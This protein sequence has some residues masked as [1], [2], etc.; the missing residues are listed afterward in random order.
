MRI[1]HPENIRFTSIKANGR[2]IHFYYEGDYYLVQTGNMTGDSTLTTQLYRGRSKGCT[3]HISSCY[4]GYVGTR[5]GLVEGDENW[6]SAYY[7][8]IK[9]ED[10]LIRY[11]NHNR[12]LSHIDKENFVE[13]MIN[14]GLLEK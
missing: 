8:H 4:G 9:I 11:K 5:C 12:T 6:I 13:K 10:H 3:E 1:D 14:L 7:S 2:L